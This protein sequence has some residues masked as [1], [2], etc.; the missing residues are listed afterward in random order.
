MF[1]CTLLNGHSSFAII[2]MGKR[3][4]V[5]LLSL[6]FWCL[7]M[8]VWLFFMVPRVCL[9]FMIVLFPDQTHYFKWYSAFRKNPMFQKDQNIKNQHYIDVWGEVI[10]TLCGTKT[11]VVTS[12]QSGKTVIKM[13]V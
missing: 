6:S 1:C 10:P 9:R 13:F 5:A 2:L 11:A 3:E 4:L 12:K 7:V 8:V